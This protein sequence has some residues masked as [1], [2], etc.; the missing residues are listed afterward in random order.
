MNMISNETYVFPQ[1]L[2]EI[3][4]LR[5]LTQAQLAEK[6]KIPSTSISH[7]ES[8]SRKPSFD[9][10]RKLGIALDV[11]TD[12]L[13]GR[14]DNLEETHTDTLF[15]DIQNLTDSDRETIRKLAEALRN[16]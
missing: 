8:G 7:L 2:K 5:K 11:S 3:R 9:N 13:L 12:Y 10:L 14:V 15:R 4:E 6:S 1:R 16:K